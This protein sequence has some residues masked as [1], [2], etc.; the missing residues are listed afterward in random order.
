MTTQ[1]S[2]PPGDGDRPACGA[3]RRHAAERWRCRRPLCLHITRRSPT[4]R[5]DTPRDAR[6][7]S[8]EGAGADAPHS[9]PGPAEQMPSRACGGHTTCPCVSPLRSPRARCPATCSRGRCAAEA[10]KLNRAVGQGSTSVSAWQPSP[11]HY[12]A[13]VET[14]A[15]GRPLCAQPPGRRGAAAK[16]RPGATGLPSLAP[17]TP[18]F[19]QVGKIH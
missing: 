3:P 2:A 18:G 17:S 14:K 7:S 16:P 5:G 9:V 10:G 8:P 4:A 13:S 1:S 11:S 15:P 6:P 12:A 19:G